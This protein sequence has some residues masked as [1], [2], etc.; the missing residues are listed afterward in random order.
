MK[1]LK[2]IT[3]NNSLAAL[4]GLIKD[5]PDGFTVDLM[6]LEQ[7]TSGYVVGLYGIKWHEGE[8]P[9]I[10]DFV[11]AYYDYRRV[12]ATK[13]YVGYWHNNNVHYLDIVKIYE[14]KSEAMEH[15]KDN[16][17]IAIYSL[18]DKKEIFVKEVA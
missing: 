10:E 4:K 15:A 16:D 9:D 17:Q 11:K 7:P 2:E 18:H 5:L 13:T 14:D 1:S 3:F 8:S 6:N 12:I